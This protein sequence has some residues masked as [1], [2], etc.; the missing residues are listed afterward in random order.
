MEPLAF[1]LLGFIMF[2]HGWRL[3]DLTDARAS[4]LAGLVGGIVL[5]V[6]LAVM[7]LDILT[8]ARAHTTADN[9]TAEQINTAAVTT[10]VVLWA[11]YGVVL[12]GAGLW[13]MEERAL[14]LYGLFLAV[15]S[16]PLAGYFL[17]GD[18]RDATVQVVSPVTSIVNLGLTVVFLLLFLCLGIPL[19]KLRVV[20]GFSFVMASALVTLLGF[21]VLANLIEIAPEI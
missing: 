2:M 13:G 17:S 15:A 6:A 21:A 5:L 7:K 9:I 20:T 11:L 3:L 12:S 1:V 18:L 4:G 16:L 10:M 8:G 19:R 14:G